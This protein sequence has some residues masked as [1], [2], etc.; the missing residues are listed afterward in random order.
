MFSPLRLLFVLLVVIVIHPFPVANSTL[1][2]LSHIQWC[3]A[4]PGATDA[5]LQ[6]KID[7]ICKQPKVN[8][9]PIESGGACFE[10]NTLMSHASYVMNAYYWIHHRAEETCDKNTSTIVV[11]DPSYGDCVYY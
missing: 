3:V 5:Q 8:C 9:K 11:N 7:W 6:E 1:R 4:S 10:P 2:N